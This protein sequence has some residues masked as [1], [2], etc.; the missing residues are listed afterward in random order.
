MVKVNACVKFAAAAVSF[1]CILAATAQCQS[2][3][4]EC[5]IG[6]SKMDRSGWKSRWEAKQREIAAFK[7]GEVDLVFVGDSITHIWETRCPEIVDEINRDFTYLNLG[8]S[9]D[10]TSNVLWRLGPGG[11][12]DGYKAKVVQLMIGT[13]DDGSDPQPVADGIRRILDLLLRKQPQAKVLLLPIFP[14]RDGDPGIP[15]AND[16]PNPRP[17]NVRVNEIIA[18]YADGRR[19]FWKDFNHR[20]LDENDDTLW[21][22]PDRLHPETAGLELWWAEVEPIFREWLGKPRPPRTAGW[23]DINLGRNPFPS[24]EAIWKA[25]FSS[26]GNF[27]LEKHDGAEG[28][29]VVLKGGMRLQKTN[30]KGFLVVKAAPFAVETNRVVSLSCDVAVRGAF[31]EYSV[32]FLRAHGAKP[33]LGIQRDVLSSLGER[34]F[35][36]PQMSFLLNTPPGMTNRKYYF[37]RGDGGA[38]TPMVVVAGKRSTSVWTNWR[39]EDYVEQNRLF[40]KECFRPVPPVRA[41]K[42]IMSDEEFD[43]MIANDIQHTAK[44]EQYGIGTRLLIDGKPALPTAYEGMRHLTDYSEITEAGGLIKAGVRLAGPIVIGASNKSQ[45]ES[46]TWTK[47]GYDA[48]KAVALVRE[49]MKASGDALLHVQYNCNAYPEFT[50]DMH[51]DE[52]WCDEKGQPIV[53]NFI[54]SREGYAGF[55]ATSERWPWPSMASPHW[56]AAVKSNIRA[57]VAEMKRRGLDKRFVSIHFAGY[58]DGQFGMSRPDYSPC[59]KAEYANYLKEVEGTGASTNYWHFCRQLTARTVNEFGLCFKEAIGK[60][61][62]VLRRGDSPFVVEFALGANNRLPGID[63]TVT[64]MT[65][66][67]RDPAISISSFVPFSSSSCNGRMMWNEFD[68]RTQWVV[69]SR[70]VTGYIENSPYFDIQRWQAG[71]R[72]LAGALMAERGGFWFY[73]MGRG[74]FSAPGVVEDVADSFKTFRKL[75]EKKPDE[76]TPDTAIVVDEEGFFGW[77]GEEHGYPGHTYHIV[78]RQLRLLGNAGVPYQFFFA[79][80]VLARPELLNGKKAVFLM[81]WRKFDDRRTSFMKRLR[82]DVPSVVFLAE[83]GSLGENDEEATGFKIE[84]SWKPKSFASDSLSSSFKVETRGVMDMEM[85]TGGHFGMYPGRTVIEPHGRRAS[86]V[87]KPGIVPLARFRDDKSV[88]IAKYREGKGLKYYV[89]EPGGLS[90]DLFSKIVAEAGGYV[91][92]R[93]YCLQVNMNG[94]FVSVHALRTGCF[95]FRLPFD[96]EVVNVKSGLA[97]NVFEGK[98]VLNVTAGQ[99][100]WFEL[101]RR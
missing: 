24:A 80:D 59:A 48:R 38:V 4:E 6:C 63:A 25:D 69:H 77:G 44:I 36:T 41:K 72:K 1:A 46:I 3:G 16:H 19:V 70:T 32:G 82:K 17:R 58:N 31:P 60:D 91:P 8:Y 39:A 28:K 47:D 50:T 53:G 14:R 55:T 23:E 62:V 52:I 74:W 49:T 45:A 84:F 100:C 15:G 65:Y 95:D 7:G 99:T 33:S 85:Y 20:F 22:M 21:C 67:Y 34:C 96:C 40:C 78:E 43:R 13:N 76:W 12:L 54:S 98:M 79:E 61:V 26:S 18:K 56:R 97:E 92:V 2:A 11:E 29:L 86:V 101:R 75:V 88:A 83:C 90:P 89:A 81:L 9:G 27:V 68:L 57:F 30:D 94:D 5:A 71:Y 37:Y 10:D 87:E 66:A 35:G 64:G 51:P 93:P 73:D 42:E